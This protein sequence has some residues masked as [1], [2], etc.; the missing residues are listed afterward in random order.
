MTVSGWN[1]FRK[2]AFRQDFCSWANAPQSVWGGA[3][4]WRHLYCQRMIYN[5]L[6][7]DFA[8]IK[9]GMAAEGHLVRA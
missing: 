5:A 1:I 3:I 4:S 9:Q 8:K 6:N 2:N 7:G